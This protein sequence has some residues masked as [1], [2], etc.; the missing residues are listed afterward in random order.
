MPATRKRDGFLHYTDSSL[1]SG[2]KRRL[3]PDQVIDLDLSETEQISRV[4]NLK[5]AQLD[6]VYRTIEGPLTKD[7]AQ[8]LIR[9]KKRSVAGKVRSRHAAPPT[10]AV[11]S[12]APIALSFRPLAPVPQPAAPAIDEESAKRARLAE[13][14]FPET[15]EGCGTPTDC[16]PEFT[17][18]EVENLIHTALKK[19]RETIS[20]VLVND[21]V[22]VVMQLRNEQLKAQ[23]I[24]DAIVEAKHFDY[25]T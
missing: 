6:A 18:S 11:S 16:A 12:S 21:Y 3:L 24:A 15:P 8:S 17:R 20:A 14:R 19:Q 1:H 2:K 9:R 10:A 23:K 13:R 22:D 4:K 5:R 25:C 7:I